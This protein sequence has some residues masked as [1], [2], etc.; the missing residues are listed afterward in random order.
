MKEDKIFHK[1]TR[2]LKCQREGIGNDEDDDEVPPL[3]GHAH[4]DLLSKSQNN[5][6]KMFPYT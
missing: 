1:P 2:H 4:D 6:N 3:E 5:G